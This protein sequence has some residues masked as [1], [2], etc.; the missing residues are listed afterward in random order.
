MSSFLKCISHKIRNATWYTR[1]PFNY[2]SLFCKRR[3]LLPGTKTVKT[4]LFNSFLKI[5]LGLFHGAIKSKRPTRS[6]NSQFFCNVYKVQVKN[7]VY[8]IVPIFD[9]KVTE[10]LCSGGFFFLQ[11]NFDFLTSHFWRN[12][13]IS[14][15]RYCFPQLKFEK[16]I[17]PVMVFV[18]FRGFKDRYFGPVWPINAR[19]ILR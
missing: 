18:K 6:D 4:Y 5:G 12:W 9:K 16:D 1:D 3:G 14:F 13:L 10:Y 8:K 2:S 15:K 7:A 11:T 19:Y 17:I